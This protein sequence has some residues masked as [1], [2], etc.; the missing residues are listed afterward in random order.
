LPP[1]DI[2]QPPAAAIESQSTPPHVATDR[3]PRDAPARHKRRGAVIGIAAVLAIGFASAGGLIFRADIAAMLG[4]LS[5]PAV[6]A[7]YRFS[8][9]L[10]GHRLQLMGYAPSEA[11]HAAIRDALAGAA[12]D[13]IIDDRLVLGRGAPPDMLDR[14]ATFARHLPDMTDALFELV[15]DQV[16]VSAT[17]ASPGAFAKLKTDLSEITAKGQGGLTLV[18]ARVSPYVVKIAIADDTLTLSGFV[19]DAALRQAATLAAKQGGPVVDRLEIAAG[20][21]DHLSDALAFAITEGRKLS[22]G[23]VTI[24]DRTIDVAG[25]VRTLADVVGLKTDSTAHEPRGFQVT[26]KTALREDV[27]AQDCDR[28]ALPPDSQDR[29]TGVTGVALDGIDAVAAVPACRQAVTA[30]PNVRRF[31]TALGAALQKSGDFN[32]AATHYRL[33]VSVDD[34]S[35][36]A[37]LGLMLR[38]GIGM[39]ADHQAA[40]ALFQRARNL[41]NGTAMYAIGQAYEVGDAEHPRDLEEAAKW[42]VRAG[43]RDSADADARLGVMALAGTLRGA[44]APDVAY[45]EFGKAALL[46]L[47]SAMIRFADMNRQ[48]QTPGRLRD[49]AK[50]VNWYGRAAALGRTEAMIALASLY[51]DGHGVAA[52]PQKARD[53]MRRAAEAGD[54]D[55]MMQMGRFDFN[56]IGA[57]RDLASAANWFEKA[58]AAG[59]PESYER[60]GRLY[61]FDHDAD[62]SGKPDY[63]TAFDWYQKGA[64]LNEPHAIYQAGLI[65]EGGFWR[66]PDYAKAEESFQRAGDLGYAAGYFQLGLMSEHGRGHPVDLTRA[67]ADYQ[68]AAN[69]GHAPAMIRLGLLAQ[70][71]SGV[72]KDDTAALVD[73]TKALQLGDAQGYWYAALLTDAGRGA[74]KNPDRVANYLLEAYQRHEAHAVVAVAGDM[75][76]FSLESRVAL[77]RQLQARGFLKG[78]PLDGTYDAAVRDAI[79]AATRPATD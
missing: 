70:N 44:P 57:P 28:L 39:T 46:G 7:P 3:A 14:I 67:A 5:G 78:A 72:P 1:A 75:A 21:P 56:G 8:A 19:P 40:N 49:Y 15:G 74:P 17:A 12:S 43:N 33:A 37:L 47:P 29:P 13:T 23:S 36:M 53:W 76:A 45:P 20:A 64:A 69:L 60:L 63:V 58:A 16:S 65:Y 2:P 55:A 25:V 50:A 52:D 6:I 77:Q 66:S 68:R 27:P 61:Q 34:A 4:D 35:A 59:H 51:L 11:A 62:G 9:R 32:A 42:Y 26:V 24:T 71:G 18:P 54:A 38:D 48:G 79:A 30:Y 73:F 10:D 41:D 22:T 31:V